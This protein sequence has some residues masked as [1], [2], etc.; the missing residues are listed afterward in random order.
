MY[1]NSIICKHNQK[2]GNGFICQ[3]CFMETSIDKPKEVYVHLENTQQYPSVQNEQ[4]TREKNNRTSYTNNSFIHRSMDIFSNTNTISYNSSSFGIST[5]GN[6]KIG[7]IDDKNHLHRSFVQPDT[8]CG[9]RFFEHK[10]TM[11]RNNHTRDIGN[12]QAS[13]FQQQ[14]QEIEKKENTFVPRFHN[15]L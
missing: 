4:Y 10:P 3:K 15:F 13:Q 1:S 6:R 7:E 12:Q 8:R 2:V 5:R 9:N 14:T 11:T